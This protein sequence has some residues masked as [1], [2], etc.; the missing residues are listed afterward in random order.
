MVF[1][2]VRGARIQ[3]AKA[4]EALVSGWSSP[5]TRRRARVSSF[6]SLAAWCSQ[7]DHADDRPFSREPRR[8]E[9]LVCVDPLAPL[10]TVGGRLA[11]P[12]EALA[13][14]IAV[15]VIGVVVG[16][17]DLNAL[18]G[19]I[20]LNA[21][22]EQVDLGQVLD[23]VDVDQVL[24]QVDLDSLLARVDIGGNPGPG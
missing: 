17:L 13:E 6:S 2:S 24:D 14:A 11:P 20:D 22:L 16:A 1:K 23:R 8:Y 19:E 5:R 4:A 15:R 18:L 3:M 10:R 12:T 9:I 7:Q 21:V